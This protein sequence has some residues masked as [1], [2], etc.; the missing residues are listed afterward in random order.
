MARN[1]AAKKLFPRENLIA[2]SKRLRNLRE[3]L[4]PTVQPG[5]PKGPEGDD[6]DEQPSQV[7]EVLHC[8]PEEMEEAEEGVGA[9]AGDVTLHPGGRLLHQNQPTAVNQ[10]WHQQRRKWDIPLYLS[11]EIRTM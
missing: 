3:I 7:R 4:S 9:E 8:Q 11:K 2:S 10:R 5:N 6:G 1:E